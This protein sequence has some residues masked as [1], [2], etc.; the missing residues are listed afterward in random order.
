MKKNGQVS[1]LFVDDEQSV[2][3]ALRRFLIKEPYQIFLA[4]GGKEALEVM[5]SQSIEIVVSDL[6]MPEMNGLELLNEIKQYYPDT[7]RLILSANRDVEEIIESI[8]RGKI[9]RFIPKPLDPVPFKRIM[10]DVVKYYQDRTQRHELFKELIEEKKIRKKLEQDARDFESKIERHLLHAT[11]PSSL[12]GASV[13]ALSIPSGHLDGD[14]YDF[15]VYNNKKIDII[16][17]DVMG[18]GIQSALVGAGIKS[19]ILKTLSTYDCNISPKICCPDKISD[20][21][22][23]DAVMEKVH[24]MS[25][26][27]LITLEMFITMCFARIDL[28]QGMMSLIDCGHTKSIHYRAASDQSVF[29]EGDSL[30]LG[31]LE[32]AEYN[33]VVVSLQQGDM[34]LFY[35]DGVTEAENSDGEMF[36]A[37]RLAALTHQH[38]NLSPDEMIHKIEDSVK[39]FSGCTKFADDFSCIAVSMNENIGQAERS[40]TPVP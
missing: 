30:P 9:F 32:T 15:V 35:S 25:I 8:N 19:I 10:L 29:L 26:E 4:S 2:L 27:K 17:A 12:S 23:I 1:I 37:K 34:L 40:L 16:M 33:P 18:K 14:F 6:R 13:A 31:I 11:P 21:L 39:A 3:S 38:H 36:G 24:A 5:A 28:D 7:I 22:R 20:L